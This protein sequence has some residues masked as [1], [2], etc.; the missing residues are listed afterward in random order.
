[1]G[2]CASEVYTGTGTEKTL[3]TPLLQVEQKANERWRVRRRVGR[4][5]EVRGGRH[6]IAVPVNQ[7]GLPIPD[8]P[9]T[10]LTCK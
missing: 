2:R 9:E 8:D 3:T 1:M 10:G 7:V 5:E 4:R 6:I